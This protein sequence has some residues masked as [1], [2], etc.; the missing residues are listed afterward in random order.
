MS[1]EYNRQIAALKP[2]ASMVLMAKAKAMKAEDPSIIDLA[3]GEPDFDT[4]DRITMEA[5]RQ[6]AKG[7]T[8]Y[9]VG[10]GLPELRAG[11]AKKLNEENG[12]SY[13]P[14]GVIVTPGAKYAIYLAV[15]AL[16]NP[17]DEVLYLNP[18]WVSYISI[19]EASGAVPVG[20][21]LDYEKDYRLEL[22]ALEA[23]ATDRTRAI[24]LNYPNNPTGRLLHADDFA[25]LKAF[26]QSHPD[27]FV[28]SDEI[29]ERI[30]YDGMET[31]SPAADPEL[32]DRVIT[33]NGFSKS[34]AM[35]GWRCGYLAA[36]VETAKI[37]YK[38]FQHTLSCV[39]GFIQKSAVV[40][41]TCQEEIE[42]MRAQFEKRRDLFTDT[43][44]AID[45]VECKKP[46]GAF[47][48]WVYFDMPGMDSAAV[49]DFILNRAK[50]VGVP[51]IAYGETGKSCMRF[52]FAASD[53]ALKQAA[54]NIAKAMEAYRNGKL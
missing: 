5:V 7:Y 12:C 32:A 28:I 13:S 21:G 19:I 27:V 40:A 33:V 44:N 46:E 24:I 45:G 54:E 53:E 25:A 39:S 49:A 1:F 42:A 11:I 52:S 23:K 41:L 37:I 48:A 18:S 26:L 29:Y 14:D 20:I 2:S 8:H 9:T 38:L 15:R 16:V 43:L 17:G 31:I 50:V 35:T 51:G 22:S 36:S 4:P 3:G 6:L 30:R 47:Y 10:P 34:V